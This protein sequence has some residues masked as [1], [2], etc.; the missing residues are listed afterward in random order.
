MNQSSRKFKN[1]VTLLLTVI[2][3]TGA[4]YFAG[5]AGFRAQADTNAQPIPFS[6]NWTNINLITVDDNWSG[7][8]GI[9]GYRGDD[10]TTAVGT[11]PRTILADGSAVVDVIAN[12][13]NPDTL[14][15]GGVAEFEI[16]NPV[17]A[18]Q[19]SGTADAPH[20]V[21]RVNATGRSNIVFAANIRDIDGSADD[22]VQQV[23]V[24]Y[25][26]GGSG[27]YT[28]VAGGYIADATTAG[29]AT[30]V[31]ALNLTLPAAA[32][33]QA[34]V[35]IRVITTN[36]TGSD[37]WVGVDDINVNGTGGTPSPSPFPE[38]DL[39]ISQ[40]DAPDPVT[41]GQPL[42]YTLTVTITPTALGG[43]A[44][45]A[46]RFNFPSG[47][48]F[49][50]NSASGTNG[51]TATPD[52]NGVTFTGG[53]VST[54][55]MNPGTATL[56]V[57]ITPHA[58]GTLTSAGGNVVVDPNNVISES[59]ENN[60]T[61]QTINTTV[62]A[63]SAP[64]GTLY[65]FTGDGRTDWTT[66]RFGAFNTPIR[67][68]VVGNPA[69]S[70]PNAAFI[71]EFDYGLTGDRIVPADYVGDRKTEMAVWRSGIYYV[72]QFPTGAGGIT[73]DRAVQWGQSSDGTGSEGDYDGD[74]KIDYTVQR[75]QNNALIWY[76]M[77]SSTNTMRAVQFG[78]QNAQG[79]APRTF[80]GADFTGDGR[81]ELIIANGAGFLGGP[82]TYVIGDAVTG[83]DIA[84]IPWGDAAI[85]HAV[86]PADYTGDGRADLVAWRG[87][88]GTTADAGVW[89]IRNTAT[90]TATATRFGISSSTSVEGDL[91]VRGDYDGDGRH[92]IAVYRRS[93]QTFYVLS[94][95]NNSLIVQQSGIAGD[96][97]LG[98]LFVF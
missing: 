62:T 70:V 86:A 92:D 42:A 80:P 8:P 78:A 10:L 17:V 43:S 19:G 28:S 69:S 68:R 81:D 24:Q 82:I 61:A 25:R 58:A 33:N 2:M 73:L 65:D 7:V 37:E 46:V 95:S 3:A 79:F 59:N 75:L 41:I 44:S 6:Q 30:Q 1:T 85:D 50:F 83:V 71:R 36:A 23:D 63:T 9:I 18:L 11:D 21:V 67:W 52:A 29:T 77:S 20:I 35:D 13:T 93:N 87:R 88:A 97:P 90:G 72:A 39:T 76:I 48:S 98:N 66:F 94:S 31:T 14:A 22:A 89:Y 16:A 53:V 26:V 5:I 45:P 38:F 49:M 32:N 15:T 74:G 96:L 27:N 47:V 51:Y 40:S 91:A 54:S 84:T 64:R 55:G 34:I 60:N 4:I 57:V 12:Q 56:T